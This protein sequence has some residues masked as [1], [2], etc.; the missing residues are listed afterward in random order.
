VAV[1]SRPAREKEKA[2]REERGGMGLPKRVRQANLAPQ[3]REDAVHESAAETPQ[4]DTDRE[5]SPDQARSTMAA[6]AR[7]LARGR[8]AQATGTTEEDGG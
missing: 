8:T 6:F 3:L 7:G 1:V 5:R 2:T 4:T